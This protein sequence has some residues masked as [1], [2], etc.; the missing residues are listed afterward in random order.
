MKNLKRVTAAV[1]LIFVLGLTAFAGQTLTPPCAP[2][3][4][5]ITN[6]PPCAS[7]QMS[8]DYSAAPGETPTPPAANAVDVLSVAEATMN[9]LLLF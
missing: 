3:E 7:A 8:P 6:T 2:P 9:L 5:G 1:V 4:P